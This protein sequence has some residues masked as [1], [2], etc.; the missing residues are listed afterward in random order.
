MFIIGIL[1]VGLAKEFPGKNG[2]A[3]V[4]SA[5]AVSTET[6][7]HGNDYSNEIAHARACIINLSIKWRNIPDLFQL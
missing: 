5:I 3:Q 6:N 4:P 2:K 1:T 7:N